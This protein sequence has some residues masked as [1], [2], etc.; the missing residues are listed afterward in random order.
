MSAAAAPARLLRAWRATEYE[1]EGSVARIGRRSAAVDRLLRRLGARQGAFVSAWNPWARRF[2]AG[3][4]E[5]RHAALR[6]VARR[7]PFAEGWGRGRGWAERHLLIAGDPRRLAVLARRFRQRGIVAVQCGAPAR[8]VLLD[9][10]PPAPT[11]ETS[12]V[13]RLGHPRGTSGCP[14]GPGRQAQLAHA[15]ASGSPPAAAARARAINGR[16]WAR[17]ACRA[18]GAPPHRSCGSGSRWYPDLA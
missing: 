6:A 11:P 9:C 12:P 18:P 14:R 2:P 10:G 17:C 7:L 16:A 5:R 3:W 1:A 4:N 8:L 15:A 13:S